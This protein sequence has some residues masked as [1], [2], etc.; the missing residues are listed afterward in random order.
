MAANAASSSL[1]LGFMPQTYFQTAV[2]DAI[3]LMPMYMNGPKQ[4]QLPQDHLQMCW[5]K[6]TE[7]VKKTLRHVHGVNCKKTALMFWLSSPKNLNDLLHYWFE[8]RVAAGYLL[9]PEFNSKCQSRNI[10]F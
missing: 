3:D 8:L 1:Q 4:S 10:P 2:T 9:T 6:C 7:K 5:Q